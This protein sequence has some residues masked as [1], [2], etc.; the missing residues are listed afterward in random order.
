MKEE[1]SAGLSSLSSLT[2]LLLLL[3]SLQ[4]PLRLDLT[5]R[6]VQT[7]AAYLIAERHLHEG[8]VNSAFL[9]PPSLAAWW[10][11]REAWFQAQRV[12][13]VCEVHWLV[14]S[15]SFVAAGG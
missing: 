4:T 8:T 10:V 14:V 2:Q 7:L 3:E 6:L 13:K 15:D 11:K 12:R 1:E 9:R 5:T